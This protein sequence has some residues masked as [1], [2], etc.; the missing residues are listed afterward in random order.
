MGDPRT[1]VRI[2]IALCSGLA[3]LPV[4]AWAGPVETVIYVST[5]GNDGWSGVIA[6]PAGGDGPLATLLG[7]RDRIRVLRAAGEASGP[8]R[9]E[10][11]GGTYRVTAPLEL[12]PEDSGA[13]G[14]PVWFE[15]YGSERPVI[16]GGRRI[17]GWHAAGDHWEAQL[18]ADFP[19]L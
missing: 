11:R 5:A 7:A 6:A 10:V 19:G 2:G 16:S 15:A 1:G 12:G 3:L 17:T 4:T 14:A 18:P 9:V 8:V 13:G